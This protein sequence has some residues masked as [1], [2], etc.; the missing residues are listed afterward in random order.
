MPT[1][2][3]KA[4]KRE[5]LATKLKTKTRRGATLSGQIKRAQ[6]AKKYARRKIKF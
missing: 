3:L 4:E 5:Q 2:P 1:K 6:T